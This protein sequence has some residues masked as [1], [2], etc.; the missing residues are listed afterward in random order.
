MD[1]KKAQSLIH[2]LENYVDYME[3]EAKYLRKNIDEIKKEL[4]DETKK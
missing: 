2:R 3:K 4:R 1:L